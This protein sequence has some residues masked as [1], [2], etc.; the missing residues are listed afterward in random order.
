MMKKLVSL[1]LAVL[2]AVGC[3]CFTAASAEDIPPAGVLSFLDWKE[4]PVFLLRP[5]FMGGGN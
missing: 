1:L 3:F 4:A 2:L 5:C